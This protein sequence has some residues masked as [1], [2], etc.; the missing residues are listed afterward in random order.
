M[1]SL[2]Y[3]IACLVFATFVND[4]NAESDFDH[5]PL[6][7]QIEFSTAETF[8]ALE[9][10]VWTSSAF[11]ANELS[12][13][14]AE[15]WLISGLMGFCTDERPVLSKQRWW[16]VRE[17]GLRRAV[18][19]QNRNWFRHTLWCLLSCSITCGDFINSCQVQKQTAIHNHILHRCS[20]VAQ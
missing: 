9:T 5:I 18:W 20:L 19:Q 13:T 10:T 16:A 11:A 1:L 4:V 12:T 17:R 7:E 2:R 15:D 8:T 6:T 3:Q 14:N